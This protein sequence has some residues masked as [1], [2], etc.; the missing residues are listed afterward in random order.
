MLIAQTAAHEC[1]FSIIVW[2]NILRRVP[3]A[4]L[5]L[6]V[7]S[8][9]ARQNILSLVAAHGILPERIAFMSRVGHVA[10]VDVS[11][12]LICVPGCLA[13]LETALAPRGCLRPTAGYPCV[14]GSHH[15]IGE[16]LSK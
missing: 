9:V 5:L 7:P 15:C 13:P 14:R 1:F 3:T 8:D 4:L 6:L 16:T 2:M 12:L 11:S 10:I